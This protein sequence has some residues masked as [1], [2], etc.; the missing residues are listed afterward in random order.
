MCREDD[1]LEIKFNPK[2]ETAN[3]D[4]CAESISRS[5]Y[6]Y[7]YSN[8]LSQLVESRLLSILRTLERL[9]AL[10]PT[11][12]GIESAP[13]LRPSPSVLNL[14]AERDEVKKAKGTL[15][16]SKKIDH[17]IEVIK[18]ALNVTEVPV[19][20]TTLTAIPVVGFRNE[21]SS[22]L[23][24]IAKFSHNQPDENGL[25]EFP[26]VENDGMNDML[27]ILSIPYLDVAR[28]VQASQATRPSILRRTSS[29]ATMPQPGQF[30]AC[31]PTPVASF[32]SKMAAR[33]A[34]FTTTATE[35]YYVRNLN[36]FACLMF[37]ITQKTGVGRSILSFIDESM[38][39]S[40]LSSL[41]WSSKSTLLS[42][43][44]VDIVKEKSPHGIASFWVERSGNSL[45]W[46]IEEI[47]MRMQTLKYNDKGDFEDTDTLRTPFNELLKLTDIHSDLLHLPRDIL[48]HTTMMAFGRRIPVL[49]SHHMNSTVRVRL[50]KII[51]GAVVM[52]ANHRILA[53]NNAAFFNMLG[54]SYSSVR[55][56]T[57][58]AVVPKFKSSM[59]SIER[60]CDVTLCP[61]TV[62]PEHLFRLVACKSRKDYFEKTPL[63]GLVALTSSGREI[64]V[65]IELRVLGPELRVLWVSFARP[66]FDADH[67]CIV[68]SQ[69]ELLSHHR[70][71][72]SNTTDSQASGI[73]P[74]GTPRS[75]R[76]NSSS[77]T[78]I[79]SPELQPSKSLLISP[80]LKSPSVSAP[81]PGTIPVPSP[82]K[83]FKVGARRRELSMK[84]FKIIKSLG[85]GAYGKVVLAQYIDQ[86]N[87]NP[88]V[89]VIKSIFK[90]R[91]LVDTWTRDRNLGTIPNEIRILTQLREK[92]HPNIIQLVDFFEDE[93][94]FH[95][96]TLRHGNPAIDLF[97]YIEAHPDLPADQC[98]S[99][100]HQVVSAIAHLHSLGIVHRDIKD[101]NVIVDEL[102]VCQLIDFGS[103]AYSRK[104]PFDVFVGTVD[105]AAPEILQGQPFEGPPQDVWAL[106]VLLYTIVYKE[107]P[108]SNVDEIMEADLH[109]P[110]DFDP[111]LTALIHA[112]LI[113][114][115]RSRP[116]VG[117]ILE[118]M[119]LE[120]Q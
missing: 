60:L 108:F 98:K 51:S 6:G 119:C 45:V 3:I 39:A 4:S 69:L 31:D 91:I 16:D 12:N 92:P 15:L 25:L 5:G 79:T 106:G 68:P 54:L 89:Y 111:D 14:V 95:M 58:D 52:D 22:W 114:N 78:S 73:S 43:V 80:R 82:T 109:L 65:D 13:G 44:L 38:Q 7:S 46:V 88:Q 48:H 28:R 81:A 105:Y 56:Q 32:A 2:L 23:Q 83:V 101:E 112:I 72:R 36:D 9:K 107:N 53:Y 90:D 96:E 33:N 55:G 117:W 57:V 34:V 85:E 64:F 113:K 77:T 17:F 103:A 116:K 50:P 66:S 49:V 21:S 40:V 75:E 41:R 26:S 118:Q 42:G 47:D 110:F 63:N 94:Y 99:I 61:G 84:D 59:D 10:E 115:F 67:G 20:D 27:E 18:D 102:G 8:E 76:S 100:F 35:P 37:G 93:T 29:L 19:N 30:L 104:G 11:K 1:C 70:R 74:L 62:L 24:N 71:D 97:D 120:S 86:D 87:P